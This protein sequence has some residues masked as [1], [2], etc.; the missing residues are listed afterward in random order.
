RMS[1]IRTTVLDDTVAVTKR[2]VIDTAPPSLMALLNRNSYEKGGFVLHMLR[3]E[4]G[5]S[6]FFKGIRAYYTKH[7]HAN[8]LTADLQAALET[9]S[10]KKLGM[11]FDQWLRRP[12][13]AEVDVTWRTDSTAKSI[14]LSVNQSGRYGLYEFPLRLALADPSGG[15]RRVEVGVP[16][17]DT[18]K[19]EL[20]I[21]GPVA[22]VE[23]DP[24]VQVLARITV[25]RQ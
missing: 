24:E 20:P 19:I 4:L 21:S 25:R 18:T 16:A 7:K 17:Q 22:R 8:A 5:D 12:G 14:L 6:A 2:P 3:S 13:Y 9:S 1:G 10:G 15:T 23:A 11:F